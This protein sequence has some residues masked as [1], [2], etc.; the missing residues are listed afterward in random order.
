M[1][2]SQK[3]Y[4]PIKK[5]V[6]LGKSKKKTGNSRFMFKAL[7]QRV[8]TTSF[9]NIPRF[10][11]LYFWTDYTK[12]ISQKI[13]KISPDLILIYSKDIPLQV[14]Q[15]LHQTYSTAIFYPDLRHP[16]DTKLITY[17]Q[18]V[19]CLFLT[20]KTQLKHYMAQGVPHAVF[21][22][23]ACD[24]NEHR[25]VKAQSHKWC[26]DVA[27]IGRPGQGYR[28]DLLQKIN[29]FF[30]LKLWGSSEWQKWGLLCRKNHIYVKEYAKIC[31][32]AKIILGCDQFYDM[33]CY[34]SNRTWIT[35]GCG[36]FLLTNYTPGLETIFTKGRHLEWY[37]SQEEC[38]DL[39]SYYL[40]HDQKRQKIAIKGYE[41][42]H[43][44]HTYDAMIDEIVSYMES[45]LYAL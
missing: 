4:K 22:L 9:I 36:G 29:H 8:P 45:G 44:Y 33:E 38:F 14:L 26:S 35:L 5:V 13:E 34:F 32:G 43:E 1:N 19:D 25:I 11:N 23:Q 31:S 7:C 41:Y 24:K 18:L 40:N 37:H 28:V 39:I 20:N 3:I 15:E 6:F 16:L 42:V 27:F 12:K 21:C 17:G 30:D 2:F 10:K